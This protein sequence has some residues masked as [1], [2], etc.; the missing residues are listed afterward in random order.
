MEKSNEIHGKQFDY[1]NVNFV[2]KNTEVTII[3]KDHGEFQQI[4]KE[5]LKSEYPCPDCH[6]LHKYKAV[7]P[8]NSTEFLHKI[9]REQGLKYIDYKT[10]ITVLY[11]FHGLFEIIPTFHIRGSPC[12]KCDE[13]YQYS[14]FEF[15]SKVNEVYGNYYNYG[16]INY[17]D[18][19]TNVKNAQTYLEREIL[20]L[21]LKNLSRELDW[22]ISKI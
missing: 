16:Y 8:K 21:I 3:C 17:T 11:K 12:P 19:K 4:P 22:Y 5:H 9:T 18:T 10:P 6:N 7:D 1:S 20:N 2:D 15:I 13:N 14:T